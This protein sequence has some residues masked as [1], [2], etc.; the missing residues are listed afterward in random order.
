M[1]LDHGPVTSRGKSGPGPDPR[2]RYRIQIGMFR[3][4]RVDHTNCLQV[5]IKTHSYTYL[6]TFKIHEKNV[7]VTTLTKNVL[8]EIRKD[9]IAFF[10]EDKTPVLKVLKV[11]LTKVKG[12][13]CTDC[14]GCPTHCVDYRNNTWCGP[15]FHKEN[16]TGDLLTGVEGNVYLD[17]E[18]NNVSV[19][20]DYSRTEQVHELVKQTLKI[21]VQEIDEDNDS[22]KSKEKVEHAFIARIDR[23][24]REG[25]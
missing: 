12:T 17:H 8:N 11:D 21:E 25:Y 6:N 2:I 14:C 18:G 10:N 7:S 13:K 22:Y 15:R 3:P 19:D 24:E 20:D 9:T 4:I 23:E 5:P 1:T 16:K